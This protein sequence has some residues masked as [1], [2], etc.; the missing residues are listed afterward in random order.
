MSEQLTLKNSK[1]K[2]VSICFLDSEAF[3]NHIDGLDDEQL[4]DFYHDI[5]KSVD[6]VIDSNNKTIAK[7][8]R[9]IS[10]LETMKNTDA[11]IERNEQCIEKCQETIDNLN[12]DEAWWIKQQQIVAKKFGEDEDEED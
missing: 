8:R 3:R 4:V 2:T 12:D 1:G 7:C 6:E 10:K 11:I 9:A 5:E